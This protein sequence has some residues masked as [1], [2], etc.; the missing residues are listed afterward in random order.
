MRFPASLG[1]KA[2]LLMLALAIQ[3]FAPQA[4]SSADSQ[5]VA[6]VGVTGI[7]LPAGPVNQ[8][9]TAEIKVTIENLGSA[10][11]SVTVT[12][13]DTTDSSQITEKTED[14]D[15]DATEVVTLA[16]DTTEASLGN[17]TLRAVAVVEGDT[18]VDNDSLLSTDA[19]TIVAPTTT[20]VGV[21]GIQVPT[22]PVS[23]G[24]VVEID[25][26]VQNLGSATASVTVTLLDTTDPSQIA[27]KTED[28]DADAAKVVTLSWDTTD[29]SL[30]N[31]TLRAVAVVEG[32]TN[33]D[34][35][36]LLSTDAV[37]VVAPATY[38]V[39]VTAV[40]V[41]AGPVTQGDTVSVDVTVENQGTSDANAAVTLL[42]IPDQ[43]EPGTAAEKTVAI[44]AGASE[45]VTLSWDTS[46]VTPGVYTIRAGATLVEDSN[47][48]DSM[49]AASTITISPPTYGVSITAFDVPSGPA[50]QGY[51]VDA[52]V[53]IK[54][55]GS[56]AAMFT[57]TLFDQPAGGPEG[58]ADEETVEIAAAATK[59]VTLSWDTSD[60]APGP[61]TFRAG[62]ALV[63]D[64]NV[65]DSRD[66][67]AI[68][69]ISPPPYAVAIAAVQVA[70]ATVIQGATVNADV[71]VEN[72][73]TSD[74]NATR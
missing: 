23:Q 26:T 65:S 53:T 48:A 70:S 21:T 33:V 15:A 32:D 6:D 71:T 19:V 40:D 43:G 50:T 35:D 46:G 20:D 7:E 45:T 63:E 17:H 28:I 68:I 18:N 29:A 11:A 22:D 12:L 61:H 52:D 30:G 44:A 56:V 58:T 59:T 16:W 67:A 60:A 27:E 25:V 38:A 9:D 31:H 54:N 4:S 39:A 10:T 2:G 66:S 1:W 37:T 42:Y 69:T 24:D 73:G 3:S 57:V 5:A 41:S 47:A 55:L 13:L 14:I 62:V 8:G 49:D 64:A 36:S 72:Q 51:V 74:A 34:N